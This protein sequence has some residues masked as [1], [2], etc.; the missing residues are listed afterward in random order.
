V[1][2]K[3]NNLKRGQGWG[4]VAPWAK[5]ANGVTEPEWLGVFTDLDEAKDIASGAADDSPKTTYMVVKI[6]WM[7]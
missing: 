3:H 4:V 1:K 5:N 2:H 6:E 7:S